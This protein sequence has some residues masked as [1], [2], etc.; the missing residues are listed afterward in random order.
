MKFGGDRIDDFK[1]RYVDVILPA[2]FYLANVSRGVE[3]LTSN[4]SATKFLD[5][6]PSFGSAGLSDVYSPWDSADFFGRDGT[7]ASLDPEQFRPHNQLSSSIFEASSGPNP[8]LEID[9]VKAESALSVFSR[10]LNL[11][12]LQSIYMPVA[13]NFNCF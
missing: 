12:D 8:S 7:L 3:T 6:E 1:S 5:F 4:S 10:M 11:L 9:L 13:V 2:Q